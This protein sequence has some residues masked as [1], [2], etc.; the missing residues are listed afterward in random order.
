MALA[1]LNS[2]IAAQY[3]HL[4]FPD[5]WSGYNISGRFELIGQPIALSF[6]G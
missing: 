2:P 3:V 1:I 6:Q 5:V 4:S